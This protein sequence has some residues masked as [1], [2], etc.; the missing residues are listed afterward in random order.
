MTLTT[1][2]LPPCHHPSTLVTLVNHPVSHKQTAA[3]RRSRLVG[4]LDNREPHQQQPYTL[5]SSNPLF[6]VQPTLT[7][8]GPSPCKYWAL[9]PFL[10]PNIYTKYIHSF[11]NSSTNCYIKNLESSQALGTLRIGTKTLLLLVKPR[12]KE[13]K[14]ILD[15][16]SKISS[17]F[18]ELNTPLPNY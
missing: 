2:Y 18:S 14:D 6:I 17:S 1:H 8:T 13:E 3:A 15:S 12:N 11:P 5:L 16:I 9:L 4:R 10:Y 7:S